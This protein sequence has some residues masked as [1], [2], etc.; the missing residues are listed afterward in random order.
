VALMPES[1]ARLF[2]SDA[3]VVAAS[4][5]YI[6]RVAPFYCLF[7][8]ALTLYFASQGAGRMAVPVVAGVVRMV[9]T[10][11]AGWLAVEKFDLGLEGVF[12]AIAVGMAVHGGLMAG[13]L[14]LAPWGP[15]QPRFK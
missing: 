6:T 11:L 9:A 14:L 4:A 8:L 5:A 13:L 3:A 7:G 1:W 10:I 15:R 12:A 2:A